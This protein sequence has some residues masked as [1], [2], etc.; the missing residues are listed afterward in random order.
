MKEADMN[1]KDAQKAALK[2][3]CLFDQLCKKSEIQYF[4]DSGTLLGAV[5]HKGFIPWD[6]DIDILMFRNE[7]EKLKECCHSGFLPK[8]VEIVNTECCINGY[9]FDFIPRITIMDSRCHRESIA[10]QQYGNLQNRMSIDIFIL[11]T[12]P[13]SRFVSFL[14]TMGLKFFY[15]LAMGHRGVL[16]PKKK[17]IFSVILSGTGRLFPLKWILRARKNFIKSCSG[18]KSSRIMATNYIMRDLGKTYRKE[19]FQE[20]ITAPFET[21]NFIIPSGFDQILRVHYGEYMTLPP[22]DQRVP[23]HLSDGFYF[24]DWLIQENSETI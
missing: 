17:N 9:F 19:W 3:L 23:E 4:I 21:E 10:D 2:M 20:T 12:V 13:E 7:Y 14:F 16:K 22:E 6:D 24:P 15:G 18:L 11:D 8:G 1:L 5:R